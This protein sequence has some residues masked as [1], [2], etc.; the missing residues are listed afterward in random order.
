MV[1]DMM[2][3]SSVIEFIK[4]HHVFTLATCSGSV[5]YCSSMFYT[6]LEKE[7]CLVFTSG[8][9]T[10]HIM[11]ALANPIVAGSIVLETETVGKIQGLQ[12]CG[13]M[14]EVH[15]KLKTRAIA[16]YLKRFPYAIL[17]GTPV[18][19]V[20]ITFTKFTDNR[21]G[22]GKKLIWEKQSMI[23]NLSSEYE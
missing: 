18:W 17:S 16:A 21:L 7:F 1:G 4:N 12:F 22:F 15:G 9:D 11:E 10:R 8:R 3:D 14:M 23:K 19:A 13:K 5:P 2:P 20:E 6:L